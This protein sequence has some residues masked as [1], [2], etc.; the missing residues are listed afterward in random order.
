MIDW[1]FEKL[2]PF[3][4]LTTLVAAITLCIIKAFEVLKWLI[5]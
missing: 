4:A 2:L 3:V 5:F 1:I